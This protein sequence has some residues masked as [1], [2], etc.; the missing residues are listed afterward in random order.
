MRDPFRGMKGT[1]SLLVWVES[2]L[3]HYISVP[4]DKTSFDLH[5]VGIVISHQPCRRV[6]TTVR[7]FLSRAPQTRPLTRALRGQSRV[8]G[9]Q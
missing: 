9:T 8:F 6:L 2:H 7:G 5:G 3:G 1:A 4:W